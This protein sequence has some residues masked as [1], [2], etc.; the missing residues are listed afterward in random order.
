MAADHAFPVAQQFNLKKLSF[1][2]VSMQA[3][4][5]KEPTVS[6]EQA[7]LYMKGQPSQ[8]KVGKHIDNRQKM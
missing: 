1:Q 5:L 2:C 8:N 7:L 4:L 6:V 3:K